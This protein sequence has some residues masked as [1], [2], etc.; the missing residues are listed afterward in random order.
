M[1]ATTLRAKKTPAA[2]RPLDQEPRTV[3]PT[4]EAAQHLNRSQQTLRKWA[5]KNTGPLRPVYV[6]GHLGWPVADLLRVVNGAA[7]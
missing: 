7:S 5:C 6:G 4:R 2:I 1:H 3:L